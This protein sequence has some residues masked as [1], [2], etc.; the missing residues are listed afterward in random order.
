L[1]LTSYNVIKTG[2][3]E[4]AAVPD[5]RAGG[6][7]LMNIPED[8]LNIPESRPGIPGSGRLKKGFLPWESL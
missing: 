7:L 8:T 5:I 1:T 4:A 6:T 3:S 2:G